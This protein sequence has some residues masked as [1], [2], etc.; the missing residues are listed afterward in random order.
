MSP[1]YT[2]LY[3]YPIQYQKVLFGSV[4]IAYC[5]EGP[6]DAPV[7]LFI[8]GL[9][10]T[11]I[12]WQKCIDLLKKDYRCIAIDL[13]G[14]GMSSQ[15][16]AYPYSMHFFADAIKDFILQL[17]LER[18]YLCG[19]SMG[20]QIAFTLAA[21]NQ[22]NVSGLI[23]CAPAGIETFNEWEKSLY[24]NTMLF[25]D[26][27]STEENSLRKAIN[28]S[29]YI[30]P[31]SAQTLIKD[32]ITLMQLQTKE[33][34]RLMM[35]KCISAMLEEPVD[36]QFAHIHVPVLVLFGEKDTLIPNKFIHPT[37]LKQMMMAVQPK[38]S[39]LQF[40]LIAQ[41]GHFLQWEKPQDVSYY[42]RSFI[43]EKQA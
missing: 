36:T 40:A 14:N 7:L 22:P 33:H 42:I 39:D 31:A 35:D 34:Y 16:M 19:H 37:S 30:L 18:V 3:P 1:D 26:M 8:H 10:H 28:N 15:D 5:D 25:V 23:Q 29:F 41:C 17:H 12:A 24:K 13:P 9:G 21:Q 38:F 27:L 43:K 4:E 11:M 20:G 2:A 6:K 32:L